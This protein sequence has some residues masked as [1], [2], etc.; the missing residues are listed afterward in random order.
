MNS[1]RDK[2]MG[3]CA[4]E[5]EKANSRNEGLSVLEKDTETP[6]P[7]GQK[8]KPSVLFL[9]DGEE[10]YSL[11][12]QSILNHKADSYFKGLCAFTSEVCNIASACQS[13]RQYNIACRDDHLRTIEAYQGQNVDFLIALSPSSVQS[14]KSL[15]RYTKFIP[16]DITQGGETSD[17]Q[18]TVKYINDQI[19]YFLSVYLYR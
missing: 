16:W 2:N 11:V 5:S 9:C 3:Q 18:I 7:N 8:I 6:K 17:R 15:P 10:G 4:K 14:G 13:L 12:A 1:Q 19:N